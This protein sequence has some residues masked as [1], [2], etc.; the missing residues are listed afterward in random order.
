MT[1]Q[2]RVRARSVAAARLA[3]AAVGGSAHAWFALRD[4][5]GD[6]AL[7][8]GTGRIEAVEID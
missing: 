1:D 6:A 5:D 4:G 7:A 3:L 8:S 2:A